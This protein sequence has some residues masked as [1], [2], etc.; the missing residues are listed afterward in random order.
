MKSTSTLPG[1]AGS[2]WA[3]QN[4]SPKP[5]NAAAS[6][7]RAPDLQQSARAQSTTANYGL[8]GAAREFV[9]DH[10]RTPEPVAVTEDL[11]VASPAVSWGAGPEEASAQRTHDSSR[12]RQNIGAPPAQAMI[13]ESSSSQSEADKPLTLEDLRRI[14]DEWK[15]REERVALEEEI[16][17]IKARLHKRDP[18]N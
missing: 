3:P 1:L 11:H 12:E 2:I 7:G 17:A 4:S 18:G 13:G 10:P 8:S 6:N 5:T 15:E 16:R 14:R 9:P